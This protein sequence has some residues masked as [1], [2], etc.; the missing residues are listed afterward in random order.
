MRFVLFLFLF[1]LSFLCVSVKL[2][3]SSPPHTRTRTQHPS[4]YFQAP[5]PG[6]TP[7]LGALASTPAAVPGGGMRAILRLE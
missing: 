3:E 6:G 1:F 7:L 5:R 2:N 4:H